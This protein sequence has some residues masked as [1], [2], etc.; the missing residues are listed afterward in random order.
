MRIDLDAKIEWG[1]GD[2]TCLNIVF[3][4]GAYGMVREFVKNGSRNEKVA[5]V[6]S[7]SHLG[8]IAD[9]SYQERS[10]WVKENLGFDLADSAMYLDQSDKLFE[11]ATRDALEV[12]VWVDFS[13]SAEYA[14][15][16]HWVSRKKPR[17]F[18]VVKP[19]LLPSTRES[20]AINA[21][22]TPSLDQLR[23]SANTVSQGDLDEFE[24]LWKALTAENAAFR[25][26]DGSGQLRSHGIDEF[27][28]VLT[29]SVRAEWEPMPT[30]VLRAMN[31]CLSSG[32]CFPGDLFFY[33]RLVWLSEKSCLEINGITNDISQSNIRKNIPI[34]S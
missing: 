6:T 2:V 12:F 19:V 22:C 4:D 34:K 33:K 32:R 29:D 30:V 11:M 25:L 21:C 16:L 23:N 17:E 26:L 27:D 15:F 28:D 18:F 3:S 5:V 13:S 7:D 14:N 1:R 31:E 24:I 9:G 8:L 20:G 10:E